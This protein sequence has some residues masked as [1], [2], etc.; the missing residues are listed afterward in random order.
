MDTK[1]TL[2]SWKEDEL[3]KLYPGYEWE[4]MNKA[5]DMVNY[6]KLMTAEHIGRSIISHKDF[7]AG[8]LILVTFNPYKAA[9]VSDIEAIAE[10]EK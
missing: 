9:L 7:R 6:G 1:I 2:K 10:I 4:T 3:K 5:E 8:A